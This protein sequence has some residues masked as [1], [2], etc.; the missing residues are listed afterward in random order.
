MTLRKSLL[1]Q[2]IVAFLF[3]EAIVLYSAVFFKY[4]QSNPLFESSANAFTAR[5][6]LLSFLLVTAFLLLIIKTIRYRIVFEVI[7][8]LSIFL[9]VWFISSLVLPEFA[10]PLA[11]ILTGIRYAAPYIIV[12]NVLLALG[13]AGVATA[14]GMSVTWTTMAAVLVVLAIYDVIAVYGTGHMVTMFKGLSEQGVIFALILPERPRLLLRRLREVN[15]N[16]GFFFLGTG[17]LALPSVFI[18]S[19]SYVGMPYAVGAAIGS[20]V[21][22]V[23]TNVLFV[24]M[25]KRP[26]P[27]LPPIA[28]GTL[29]GFFAVMGFQYVW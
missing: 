10:F 21:G 2:T 15:H 28:I 18:A 19:A 6:F 5:N 12:Q 29:L 7:F 26:M 9:G 11:I 24:F 27:A 20:L 8:G 4:V 1:I 3:V 16:E 25:K 14:I 17:D 23:A 13:I 22:L